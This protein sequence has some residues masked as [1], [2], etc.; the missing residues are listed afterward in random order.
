[1]NDDKLANNRNCNPNPTKD[2]LCLNVPT[3]H[4]CSEKPPDD[5]EQVREILIVNLRDTVLKTSHLNAST[6]N[7]TDS[8]QSSVSLTLGKVEIRRGAYLSGAYKPRTGLTAAALCVQP[9]L[10]FGSA[11]SFDQ[12]APRTVPK[13]N[14]RR[15]RHHCEGSG[16]MSQLPDI[17]HWISASVN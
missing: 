14:H 9:I 15:K 3:A 4:V 8:V 11:R 17:R 16:K 10:F 7:N 2:N 5:A 6:R 13:T 1:M 12:A